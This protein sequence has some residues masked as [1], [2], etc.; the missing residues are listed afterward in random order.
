MSQPEDCELLE[1]QL[2]TKTVLRHRADQETFDLLEDRIYR[3]VNGMKAL[4]IGEKYD[5]TN[6]DRF[7]FAANPNSCAFCSMQPICRKLL[8]ERGLADNTETQDLSPSRKERA[9]GYA[10]LQLF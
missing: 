4:G 5:L 10:Q 9:H 2:L 8:I 7:D 3:S 6:I 1:V